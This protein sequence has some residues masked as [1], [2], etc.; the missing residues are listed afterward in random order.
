[1][2][3]EMFSK[4]ILILVLEMAI[5]TILGVNII[6]DLRVKHCCCGTKKINEKAL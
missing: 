2:S 5:L 4:K 6:K 1:M 3:Q